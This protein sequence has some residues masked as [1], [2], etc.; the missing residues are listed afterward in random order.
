MSIRKLLAVVASLVTCHVASSSLDVECKDCHEAALNV[1]L[2]PLADKWKGFG[3]QA[4]MDEFGCDERTEF[5]IPGNET[6]MIMRKLYQDIVGEKWTI[7]PLSDESG[8]Q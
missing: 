4:F 7:A 6:W 2:N 1:S 5:K 8:M 3:M